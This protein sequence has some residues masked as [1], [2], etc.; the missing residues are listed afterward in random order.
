[1]SEHTEQAAFVEY[2]L[3]EFGP[4]DNFIRPLFFAV[5]NGAVL[6][7]NRFALMAK[8]KQEG[9][10]NGVADVLYLQPRGKYNCLAIEMK[11][12]KGK[13]TPEQLE[14]INAVHDA[15]GYSC[16]CYGSDEAI[17]AFEAYMSLDRKEI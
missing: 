13:P 4:C 6:G 9:L 2:I 15:G 7:G 5:P 11:S 10:R 14:F 3:W 17:K 12:A 8:L 16:I 1:M